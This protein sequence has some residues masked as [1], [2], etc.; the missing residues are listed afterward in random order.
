MNFL[1]IKLNLIC[2]KSLVII[3]KIENKTP[4]VSKHIMTNYRRRHR[5]TQQV[6]PSFRANHQIRYPEVRVVDE[7]DGFVG[8][9]SSQDALRLANEKEKDL[10]E[11]NPKA[12]PPVVKIMDYNKFKY[13]LQ[14]SGTAKP[15]TEK[16]KTIRVSVRIGPHDLEVQAKKIEE[17]LGKGFAVKMQVQMKGREKAYPHV[18]EEVIHNFITLITVPFA[19]IQEP[20]LVADSYFATVKSAPKK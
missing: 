11:I 4:N 5:S 18:A 16:D 3:D 2:Q 9:M 20:K 1:Y 7:E 19:Y 6:G 10:V 15:K 13:H 8:L 17:F 12:N 14:K